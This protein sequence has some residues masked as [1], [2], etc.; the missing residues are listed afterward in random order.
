MS[1]PPGSRWLRL[2]DPSWDDP[3]DATFAARFGGRWTPV[4]GEP[5]LYLCADAPTAWRIVTARL[6]SSPVNVEDVRDEAGP[7]LVDVELAPPVTAI[8]AASNEGLVAAGLPTSYPLDGVDGDVVGH[9][10]CRPVGAAAAAD[11]FDGVYARSAATRD[12]RGRELAWFPKRRAARL[13][14]RSPFT[15]WSRQ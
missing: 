1:W 6:A 3:L 8:D 13:R 12:G 10:D 7:D 2:A 9:T 5:T 11:E 15:V 14:A 4:G